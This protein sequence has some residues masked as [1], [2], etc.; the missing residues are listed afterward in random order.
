MQILK[1]LHLY[2]KKIFILFMHRNLKLL[3]VSAK[4]W[5]VLWSEV[6]LRLFLSYCY[7]VLH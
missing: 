6:V 7:R 2:K 1:R 3:K 5:S 4:Q